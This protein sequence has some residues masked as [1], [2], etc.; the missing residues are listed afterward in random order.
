MHTSL[1]EEDWV[2]ACLYNAGGLGSANFFNESSNACPT[3]NWLENITVYLLFLML[4]D[5]RKKPISVIE[6]LSTFRQK[7][8]QVTHA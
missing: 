3:R 1:M 6:V 5:Q 8:V 4:N 7:T 2:F